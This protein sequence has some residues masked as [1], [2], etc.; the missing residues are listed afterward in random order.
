ML[1]KANIH[2]TDD[3]SQLNE[4][5]YLSQLFFRMNGDSALKV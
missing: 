2:T 1:Q 4:T 5:P 3:H